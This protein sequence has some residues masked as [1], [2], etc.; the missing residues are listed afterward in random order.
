MRAG[1]CRGWRR[2]GV[3]AGRRGVEDQ[4]ELIFESKLS[5]HMSLRGLVS[6][7]HINHG[8][9]PGAQSK[10]TEHSGLQLAHNASSMA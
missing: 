6:L 3:G 1:V 2:G 9:M 5:L 7:R 4:A 10:Q 8:A